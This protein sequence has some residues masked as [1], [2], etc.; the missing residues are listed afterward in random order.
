[1]STSVG[2]SNKNAGNIVNDESWGAWPRGLL[3]LIIS[4][5]VGERNE[6]TCNIK[7]GNA[8]DGARVN[9]EGRSATF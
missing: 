5:F 3:Y 8:S 2:H 7:N 4:T 6:E 1:M 9:P